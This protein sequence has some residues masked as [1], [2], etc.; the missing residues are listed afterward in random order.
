[1]Y[2]QFMKEED[3]PDKFLIGITE[4]N[5]AGISFK[6]LDKLAKPGFKGAVLITKH[7]TDKFIEHVTALEKP[8]MVHAT[9]T[10]YGSTVLEPNVPHPDQQ[11]AMLKKLIDAGFPAERCI[12]RIDPIFPSIKGL[13]KAKYVLD[14]FT[15]IDTGIRRIKIS[16]VDEYYHVRQRYAERE[17]PCLYTNNA[18]KKYANNEQTQMVSDLLQQYDYQFES[19]AEDKLASIT[20][21]VIVKGC[22]SHTD[23]KTMGLTA[24]EDLT[25]NPQKRQGCHCLSCKRQ[26]FP[27]TDR[28]PCPHGCVYCFW[29]DK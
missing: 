20:P 24:P 13:E 12:L 14:T 23:I 25:I 7:I 2:N 11:L 10:G 1:M 17:W 29:Q 26:L 6:W 18:D 21:N 3:N 4:M 15:A 16:I 22:I 8:A 5:D 27:I 9:C 19:C 28:K